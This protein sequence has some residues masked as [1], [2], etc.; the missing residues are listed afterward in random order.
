ME[1]MKHIPSFNF[2]VKLYFSARGKAF[3][4]LIFATSTK[5]W[6]SVFIWKY[7]RSVRV[8][9]TLV[10]QPHYGFTSHRTTHFLVT[11]VVTQQKLL[12]QGAWALIYF[13]IF[14]CA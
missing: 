9:L 4:D 2:I 5:A 10:V 3:H 14:I 12:L 8:Q 1:I 13:A 7:L 11:R 6:L